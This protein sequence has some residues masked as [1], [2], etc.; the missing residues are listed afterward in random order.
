MWPWLPE[1]VVVV[2]IPCLLNTRVQSK[3]RSLARAALPTDT[4]NGHFQAENGPAGINFELSTL[5]GVRC[6]HSLASRGKGGARGV[7]NACCAS[8]QPV[9]S[10]TPWAAVL[11]SPRRLRSPQ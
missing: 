11:P 1:R 9:E 3:V 4:S 5:E 7:A 10:S 2:H 6:L 8:A